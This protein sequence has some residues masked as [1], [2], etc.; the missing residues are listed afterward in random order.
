[1][2]EKHPDVNH[3]QGQI[4]ALNWTETHHLGPRPHFLQPPLASQDPTL[5]PQCKL[6]A[7]HN[8]QVGL[9]LCCVDLDYNNKPTTTSL[10]AFFFLP[11]FRKFSA[12][13]G[14]HGGRPEKL[15]TTY[16]SR[17]T[18]PFSLIQISVIS[19]QPTHTI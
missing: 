8:R 3:I 15:R 16:L 14:H 13:P 17:H 2:E 10:D 9:L 12:H 11:P 18:K 7:T 19:L 1:M 5:T 4:R 6:Q